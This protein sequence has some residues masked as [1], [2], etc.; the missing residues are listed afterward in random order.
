MHNFLLLTR[1][2]LTK[3]NAFA[4]FEDIG[5]CHQFTVPVVAFFS[6]S[7]VL[8]VDGSRVRVLKD[9]HGVVPREVSLGEAFQLLK[10]GMHFRLCFPDAHGRQYWQDKATNL[11]TQTFMPQEELSE[12][13]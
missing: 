4:A 13:K 8:F 1:A 11:T 5:S 12:S 2:E 7:L 6:A 10:P 9:R 3:D